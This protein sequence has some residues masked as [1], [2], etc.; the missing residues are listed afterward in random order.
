[1]K[2]GQI[3][4]LGNAKFDLFGVLKCL[5]CSLGVCVT[6]GVNGVTD[7]GWNYN[8]SLGPPDL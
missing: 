5:F 3:Q 8:N 2:V 4:L 6:L 7:V 1:M